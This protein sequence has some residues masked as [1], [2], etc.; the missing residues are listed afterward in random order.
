MG[1]KQKGIHKQ[2]LCCRLA[3]DKQTNTYTHTLTLTNKTKQNAEH[4]FQYTL[5]SF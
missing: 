3:N 4:K 5:F 1:L 2:V